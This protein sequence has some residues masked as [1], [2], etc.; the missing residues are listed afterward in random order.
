M[1]H[2]VVNLIAIFPVQ[3]QKISF[4]DPRKC[5]IIAAPNAINPL[6]WNNTHL[7]M[8]PFRA[9]FTVLCPIER[10]FLYATGLCSWMSNIFCSI[11]PNTCD[12]KLAQKS[13]D[14]S[15]KAHI[16]WFYLMCGNFEAVNNSSSRLWQATL[17]PGLQEGLW[18]AIRVNTIFFLRPACLYASQ[19]TWFN[20]SK[21]LWKTE[22]EF[23]IRR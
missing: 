1:R 9:L 21:P 13:S 4:D 16:I 8:L 10:F 12:M 15:E 5:E 23:H 6:C 2:A 7:H 22:I 19:N 18:S 17:R 14:A 11:E 20:S 3:L